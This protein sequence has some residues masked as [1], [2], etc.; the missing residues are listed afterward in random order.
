MYNK[1]IVYVYKRMCVYAPALEATAST[2]FIGLPTGLGMHVLAH[3]CC[4]V[5]SIHV[6]R[7]KLESASNGSVFLFCHLILCTVRDLKLP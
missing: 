1:N 5:C 3:M 7:N 4:C 6:L 2:V